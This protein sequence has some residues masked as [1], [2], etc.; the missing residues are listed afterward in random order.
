MIVGLLA[1]TAAPAGGSGPSGTWSFVS[2]PG[3][4]PPKL[5][6]RERRV[7]LDQGD[8]LISTI[9]A[10][11]P[12]SQTR[13][14][15]V[16]LDGRAR[17]LWFLPMRQETFNFEQQTYEG[18][19]VLVWFQEPRAFAPPGSTPEGQIGSGQVVIYDEHYR[20]I[21]TIKA[22]SP[23]MTDLHDGW[24]TGGDI[25]ITVVRTVPG[26][27]LS[28][29]G[30]PRDGTVLDAGLQEFQISSGRLLRTWDALNPAGRPNVPLSASEEP[31]VGPGK[32]GPWDAYHLNSV[33]ALPGGDL[34]V[35]M[36]N[37]SAVYLID[38]TTDRIVWTLGGRDSS[39]EIPHAARFAWQHDARL[40][41]PGRG[42]LGR[43]TELTLFDDANNAY[44]K[45]PSQG[46]VLSLDTVTREATLVKAYRHR[47]N[48]YT[49]VMG[50]MQL[51]PNGNALVGWGSEPYF[52]EY[53]RSGRQLLNVEWPP[54]VS[55]SYR[56]LF[57]DTWVGTPHYPPRGAVRGTT[58]YASWNGATEVSRW[59]V[60][61]GA[62]AST[63]TVVASQPRRGFE[64]AINL[65]QTYGAYEVRALN[66]AGNVLGTS[67]SF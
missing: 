2:A 29:Y 12:G 19:P 55:S 57:T 53:S 48:L 36:R 11:R 61:A 30:G 47:P 66:A 17:P 28:P 5:E 16:L 50:S 35:S 67:R 7:G 54:L 60:L 32:P 46:L 38:P 6:V 14:G 42:A 31:V 9:G 37:T 3:L 26:Q 49:V 13:G 43:E 64:T 39:L 20:R 51:L 24:I 65:G 44:R 52:S 21:A 23:W 22:V 27:D 1:I 4:H 33:Q 8:F 56:T 40:I 59:E 25:W 18:H 34:L 62:S 45:T 58:V 41:D 63:L 15:P 10:S